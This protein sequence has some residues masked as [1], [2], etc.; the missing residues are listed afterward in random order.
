METSIGFRNPRGRDRFAIP[1]PTLGDS[2]DAGD[3]PEIF[4]KSASDRLK[5]AEPIGFVRGRPSNVEDRSEGVAFAT[6]SPGPPTR[7]V[8]VATEL[9]ETPMALAAHQETAKESLPSYSTR[10][11]GK[12]ARGVTRLPVKVRAA[13]DVAASRSFSP[14]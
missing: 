3:S 8:H 5:I 2:T 14:S 10:I 11:L 1:T 7:G 4:S 6:S 13:G 12:S 9:D